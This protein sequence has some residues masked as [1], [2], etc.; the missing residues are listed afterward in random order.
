MKFLPV[1][2]WM[3]NISLFV[4]LATGGVA[5]YFWMYSDDMLRTQVLKQFNE[6]APELKLSVGRTTLQGAQGATLSNIEIR[7]RATDDVL[8]R[9]KEL[10]VAINAT[11]LLENQKAVIDR[12]NLK[13]ADIR[14]VRLEDGRWNWQQYKYIMPKNPGQALPE[15]QLDDVR[16]HLTLNHGGGIP[17]A[18]L[19]ITS[20]RMQAVPASQHGYDFDG[21]LTLPGAGLLK[22]GGMCDLLSGQWEVGGHLKNVRADQNLMDL[23]HKTTPQLQARLDQLDSV[24]AKALPPTQTASTHQS[25]AALLIG[26]NASVAPQIS[27]VLDIDFA[28]KSVPDSPIP[29]FQLRVNVRDGV[30]ASPVFPMKLSKV[31]ATLYRD[32]ETLEFRLDEAEGQGARVTGNLLVSTAANADPPKGA[33][34]VERFPISKSLRPLLPDEKTLRMFDAFQPEGLVSAEGEFVKQ[35]DGRWKPQNLVLD[36]HSGSAMFHKFRYPA[37]NLSGKFTQ[38]PE[39]V[40]TATEST[41]AT[42]NTDTLFDVVI[43][44]TVGDRPLNTKGWM[45]NPGTA[46]ENYFTV[47]VTEFPLD[48]NFRNALDEKQRAVF[49]ALNLSGLANGTLTFYRPPGI[50][51]V[52][53]PTFNLNVYDASMSFHKF[54]YEIN[55]LTGHITFEGRTKHWKFQ[56][57]NGRH[58][59]AQLTAFGDFQGDP[60][61]GTLNLTIRAKN[62]PLDADLYNALSQSQRT[63]WQTVNPEGF[64]DLTTLINWTASPGQPAIVSFPESEPVRIYN[65]KIRPKPFPFDML[66]KEATLSFDPNDPRNA[67]KQ[68]CEILSF[69]AFH[70]QAEIRAKGWAELARDGEWQL[71]LNDVNATNLEPNIQLRAALPESWGTTLDRI[72]QTG[73]LSIENSEMDCRGDIT[74]QRNTTAQWALNMEFFDCAF[75]AGLDVS[76]VYGVVT[77]NGVWDGFHIKNGGRIHLET[78]EVL[79]MPFTS[80]R[81]PYS[82]NDIE[83]NLGARQV[84]ERDSALSQIDPDTRI[85]AR[86][87]GGEL[88]IDAHVD[89]R[90]DGKYQFF[91]ELNNARLESYAALHIPDQRNLRGVVTAW[92]S[93]TGFGDDPANLEG[94]GQLRISPAALLELPVMVKL[95][96]SLSQLNLNVQ[97]LTAFNY[98]LVNFN[99]RDKAFWLRPVDLVGDSVSFRGEGSVDFTGAVN[100]DFY[101]RPART[102]A[103]SIPLISGLF[104]NWSKIEVR[105]TTERPHVKP[106]ALGK[107]DESMKQFLQFNPNP[108]APIPMLNV[109]KFFQRSQPVLQQRR[110]QNAAGPLG[111][112]R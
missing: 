97:N 9:A 99:V 39:G 22:V 6:A 106:L 49:A 25:G 82:Q 71:H 83:V 52:T 8:F 59:T 5:V 37:K 4:A 75:N 67:G 19:L 35:P 42:T 110:L 103:A 2:K 87:Y 11:R 13:S 30:I 24:M 109:P 10:H 77:A 58:G 50:D 80:V 96:G 76:H 105:G 29:A 48:G 14:L 20:P 27:G 17:A 98:A 47:K 107:V 79:E 66:V 23:A 28:V 51:Q 61:P 36:V 46:G 81:G 54:P 70:D 74:G 1:L 34:K 94:S 43:S 55:K 78:A 33:F 85:K 72:A 88:L 57:L 63:L 32:N 84:F 93:L 53:Q 111:G 21:A 3:I 56:E 92:M 89:M 15:I 104:T 38:L 44:G 7:D 101:S 69:Q 31:Q 16:I 102:R 18:G 73:S 41:P 91:T 40:R 108:N 86:A 65:T 90:P 12:I 100:L 64:C 45:K 112:T 68:H 60:V 95:L 26:N 62:A